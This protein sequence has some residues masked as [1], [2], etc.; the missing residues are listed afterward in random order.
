MPKFKMEHSYS[1]HN[2]LPHMGMPSVFSNAANLTK[3]SKDRGLKV[4]EVSFKSHHTVKKTKNILGIL[5]TLQT[6]FYMN[7]F[8]KIT[9]AAQ[10]CD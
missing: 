2:I 9:G 8:C 7:L 6:M 1:L 5:Q 10:G 3:L 4:S